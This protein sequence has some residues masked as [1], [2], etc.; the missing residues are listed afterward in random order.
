MTDAAGNLLAALSPNQFDQSVLRFEDEERF[1]WHY[2]PRVRRGLR[3]KD[4]TAAQK[5]LAQALLSG[6]GR[7]VHQAA[8]IEPRRV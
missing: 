8:T 3:F 7:A 1:N 4:M 2:V 6:P 5:H